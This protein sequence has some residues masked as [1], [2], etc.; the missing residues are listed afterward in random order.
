M[1]EEIKVIIKAVTE[2]AVKATREVA[3][4]LKQVDNASKSASAGLSKLEKEIDRQSKELLKLKSAYIDAV[5]E[6]GE[7][8]EEAKECG[9]RISD[10]SQELNTNKNKL[11]ETIKGANTYD[12]TLQGTSKTV[13]GA[14]SKLSKGAKAALG[15]ALTVASAVVAIVKAFVSAAKGLS[16]I[17]T[18]ALELRDDLAKLYTAFETQGK[19]AYTAQKAYKELYS[20]IGEVDTSV[21]AA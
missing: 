5:T 19:S 15:V 2:Q 20:V 3:K 13:T 9:R 1:N 11:A 12:K 6:Y 18:E 10:L 16:R 4:E 17:S 7:F 8:S 21:E 14:M